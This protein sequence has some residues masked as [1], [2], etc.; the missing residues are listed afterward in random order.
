MKK[1]PPEYYKLLEEIQVVDFVII[2]L[3]HYLNTHPQDQEAINQ[4]NEYVKIRRSL[5]KTF[6]KEFGALTGF[7]YY[8]S[9]YPWDWKEAPWPWQ[10]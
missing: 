1:M 2:E 7:G 5:V 8:Y 3:N 6:E 4:Y 9:K 10:V